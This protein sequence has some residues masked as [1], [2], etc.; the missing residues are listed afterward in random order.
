MLRLSRLM[1]K[2][3]AQ[4]G[5]ESTHQANT[6]HVK[7]EVHSSHE[8]H[9]HDGHTDHHDHHDHHG[10][11]V[12]DHH[13]THH[14]SSH[15]KIPEGSWHRHSDEED[16][17]FYYD[18]YG[19]FHTYSFLGFGKP[20][21]GEETPEDEIYRHEIQGYIRLV[22]IEDDRK[23]VYRG[24]LEYLY[25]LGALMIG[26]GTLTRRGH[27]DDDNFD[28][29]LGYALITAQEIDEFLKQAKEKVD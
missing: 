23:N 14:H 10:H 18:R 19:P 16:P 15:K 17:Y 27:L 6:A 22:D 4:H 1:R 9:N 13:L 11:E 25:A 20:D 29:K 26:I 28:K 2:F 24:Y 12:G 5:K 7:S 8:G 21:H 3:G